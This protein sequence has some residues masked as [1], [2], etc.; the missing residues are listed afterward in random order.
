MVPLKL[1]TLLGHK[2]VIINDQNTPVIFPKHPPH[3]I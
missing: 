3:M 2:H 1:P